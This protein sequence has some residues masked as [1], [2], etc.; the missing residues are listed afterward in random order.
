MSPRA[1][2]I[3]FGSCLTLG[4]VDL[5]WLDANAARLSSEGSWE[6]LTH[7]PPGVSA[8]PRPAIAHA[9]PPPVVAREVAPA[10][11][12]LTPDAPEPAT[13]WIIQF[14]RSASVIPSDQMASLTAIAEAV[15]THPRAIVR[16]AGHADRMIWKANRG[17]N[18]SLS[19][20]RAGAVARALGNLGVAP[21]HIRRTAF[22]DTRPLD[23]RATEDA[24]R[25][26]RRVDVRVE[27]P[28]ER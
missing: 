15:K 9:E 10:S 19:E 14:E 23:G 8:E 20:E 11:P 25:R 3:I 17:N 27:L 7:P 6:L 16:I 28:G 24:Y 26:N 4:L 18:L 5:A 12:S 1:L 13:S 22:G 21:D 2:R